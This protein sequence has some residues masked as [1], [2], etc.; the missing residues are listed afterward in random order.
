MHVLY[1]KSFIKHGRGK[2]IKFLKNDWKL[3]KRNEAWLT[4]IHTY[5]ND[6][7]LGHELREVS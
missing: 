7:R 6:E 3:R 5:F 1:S 2:L 4:S